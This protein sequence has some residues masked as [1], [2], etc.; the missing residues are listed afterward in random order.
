[1]NAKKILF[2]TDFSSDG[3][4]GL[5]EAAAL[6]RDQNA[7]LLILHVEEP[8]VTYGGG[9]FYCGPSELTTQLLEKMLERIVPADASVRC[10]HRLV[11]GSPADEIVGVA[12]QEGVGL[13][14][15][16][17]HGRTGIKRLLMGSVAEAVIRSAPCPVLIYRSP[18]E[19]APNEAKSA[20]ANEPAAASA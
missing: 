3:N 17:T 13:I 2:P 14:V 9:E 4:A 6:A 11:V 5:N 8:P 15:M 19:A 16:G 7:T 18:E 20:N 10:E 12:R 1:M